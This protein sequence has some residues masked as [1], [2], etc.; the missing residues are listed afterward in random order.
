MEVLSQTSRIDA[1][2]GARAK[3]MRLKR[4]L[5]IASVSE[6]CGISQTEYCGI[7]EG[8]CPLSSNILF[9]LC[10]CFEVPASSFYEGIKPND[11]RASA[12]IAIRILKNSRF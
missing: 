2:I 1:M 3:I 11:T 6:Y 5:N 10:K 8:R 12:E 7:E 9:A 4:G